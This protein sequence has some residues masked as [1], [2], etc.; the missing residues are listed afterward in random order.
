VGEAKRRKGLEQKSREALAAQ[1]EGPEVPARMAAAIRQVVSALT[2]FHG[3]DCLLWAHLGA[4][5]L[6]SIGVED[7]RAVAGS[8][9][10]RIGD[11]DS[12]VISHAREIPNEQVFLQSHAGDVPGA[13]FHAWVAAP[14][15]KL[16]A[17]FSTCTL[18]DK[19]RRLDEADG[20]H[21]NVDW[22]PEYV[23][24]EGHEGPGEQ[25]A[26]PDQVRRA[27]H[28]GAY[29]YVRHPDIEAKVLGGASGELE[30][31]MTQ[32]MFAARTAY[33]AMRAGEQLR[34]VGVDR[35]GSFQETPRERP[36]ERFR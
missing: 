1:G 3:A 22:C 31:A 5:L 23:W 14:S 29:C 11:G 30:Q 36:L 10:W 19:A 7:A 24:I 18:R 2:D 12:D 17:D 15:L 21:T 4:D 8:A 32:A 35:D 27:P 34:I 20:G 13:L 16:L 33:T 6:R 9:V 28:A 25:L 26:T